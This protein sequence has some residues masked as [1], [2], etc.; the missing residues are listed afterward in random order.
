MNLSACDPQPTSVKDCYMLGN[1]SN[2]AVHDVN[3]TTKEA[4]DGSHCFQ[5]T[6]SIKSDESTRLIVRWSNTES[7]IRTTTAM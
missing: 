4:Y 1:A 3:V 5:V 7:E 2:L 6:G